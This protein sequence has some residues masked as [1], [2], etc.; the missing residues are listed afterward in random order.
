[1]VFFRGVTRTTFEGVEV[2]DLSELE[3]EPEEVVELTLDP[4]LVENDG[5]EYFA[6]FPAGE[7]EEEEE[8]E[9]PAWVRVLLEAEDSPAAFGARGTI[10]ERLFLLDEVFV[11]WE[12]EDFALG[13]LFGE[14]G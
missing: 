12:D 8:E 5:L 4:D 14:E 3:D 10:A 2:E 13:A 1:M 7:A 9:V 11:L 6:D